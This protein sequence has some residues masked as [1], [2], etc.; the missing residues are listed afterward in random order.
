[1]VFG[2]DEIS[3]NLILSDDS[4]KTQTGVSSLAKAK[5]DCKTNVYRT[6]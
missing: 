6:I 1:M 4:A 3:H 5:E 2:G